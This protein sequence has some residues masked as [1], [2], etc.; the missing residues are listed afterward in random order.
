[1][2]LVRCGAPALNFDEQAE[3]LAYERR[4]IVGTQFKHVIY[5][6]AGSPEER[7]HVY[8]GGDGTPWLA[9]RPAIDPT[10]RNPLLLRLLAMD[11]A[12]AIYLGRP[13]Y[14][15][16]AGDR[17][18]APWLWT[19]GRYSEEVVAS[20]ARVVRRLVQDGRHSKIAWFGYSGGGTLAVLLAPRFRETDAVVTIAANLDTAA[21]AAYAWGGDLSGSLNPATLAPL[22][23]HIWQRHYAGGADRIVPP[24]LTAPAASRLGAEL[25]VVEDY[26]HA[27]CWEQ[28][29]P[30]IIRDVAR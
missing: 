24:R 10:P 7:L 22:P 18:C 6:K 26:D 2:V 9:G 12:P 4:V 25:V 16:H 11:P 13:C 23:A 29:W 3:N 15:G 30:G 1:M 5:A 8:L 27:C 17:P 28:L 20:L 19:T 14:H 21:W